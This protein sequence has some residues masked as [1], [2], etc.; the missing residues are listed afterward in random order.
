MQMKKTGILL[1]FSFILLSNITAQE[2][3]ESTSNV[4]EV[5]GMPL[6]KLLDAEITMEIK[7]GKVIKPGQHRSYNHFFSLFGKRER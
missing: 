2:K 3:I 7:E 5:E 6:E 4:E 1:L